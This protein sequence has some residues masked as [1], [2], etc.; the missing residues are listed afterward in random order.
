MERV[1]AAGPE[2]ATDA[3]TMAAPALADAVPSLAPRASARAAPQ[4]H[5][6]PRWPRT[7]EWLPLGYYLVVCSCLAL[8]SYPARRIALLAAVV[9]VPW[10]VFHALCAWGGR[11]GEAR[12]CLNADPERAAWRAVAWQSHAL[13]ISGVAAAI[14]GGVRS[15]LLVTMIAA[16]A[17]AVAFVGDRAPT[18]WLLAATAAAVGVLAVLPRS[19]TG[20]EL[21]AAAHGVLLV[22]SVAGLGALLAPAHAWIRLWRST[23]ARTCEEM[24]SDAL[25]QAQTLEQIG[26]KVAHELK[27]PLTGVKALVQ[28]GLRNASEAPSHE[29]LELVEREVGRMQEILHNYL[30]FTRPLQGLAPKGLALGPLV[31]DAM[32]VLSARADAARVRLYTE[33]DADVEADPRRLREAL[34][35]LV[36]NAIEATPPGGEVQ[37]EVRSAGDE[38]EIVVRDTGK[39]MSEETL[40]RIG[41]PFFTTRDEGTG[42]GVVLAR[43]VIVQH[44]GTLRYESAPGQGTRVRVTLPRVARGARDG[45]CAAGR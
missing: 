43:S 22:A 11:R 15:P 19:W 4:L 5:V 20:P 18:R 6:G 24:A 41:T 38:A 27:N 7:H 44:G 30:S 28:L 8:A 36:V 16:Y 33:G 23:V 13:A 17:G 39:G 35:N 21:P 2:L 26:T 29:R 32:M 40:R 1:L 10:T 12:R 25:T 9:G 14:T 37:V 45:S 42:L 3:G 31:S 34:L